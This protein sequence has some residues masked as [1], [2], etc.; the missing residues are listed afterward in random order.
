MPMSM[1]RSENTESDKKGDTSGASD[2]LRP[3]IKSHKRHKVNEYYIL[4]RIAQHFSHHN[5]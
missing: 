4:V 2:S 1:L 5:K 3:L